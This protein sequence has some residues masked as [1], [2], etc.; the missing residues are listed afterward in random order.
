MI[1]QLYWPFFFG[2]GGPVG[3]G[4][5]FLPWIH[6]KD[7]TNMFLFAME[8]KKVNGVLNGVAPKVI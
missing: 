6:V 2:V 8:Q 7:I 4:K 5:Q 3:S 1:Q